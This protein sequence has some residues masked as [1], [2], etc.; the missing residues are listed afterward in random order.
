M[1]QYQRAC[2]ASI[3]IA[4]CLKCL[5]TNVAYKCRNKRIRWKGQEEEQLD[6][7]E[8]KKVLSAAVQQDEGENMQQDKVKI[9]F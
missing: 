5:P 1:N 9:K 7:V 3:F 6:K 8:R 4:M 2:R